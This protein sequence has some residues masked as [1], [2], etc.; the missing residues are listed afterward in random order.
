MP[1]AIF[2]LTRLLFIASIVF[3]MGYVFGN[4]SKNATLTK[5]TKV[6]AVLVLVAFIAGNIFFF[7][8]NN[9]WKCGNFNYNDRFQKHWIQKD[10]TNL[11]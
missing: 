6:S 11:K 2:I 10:S 8:F 4:F 7:R 1:V 3:I 5:L 9:R